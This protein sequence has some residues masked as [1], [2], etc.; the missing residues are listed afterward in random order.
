VGKN[1]DV[2]TPGCVYYRNVSLGDIVK[3]A[4]NFHVD[5]TIIVLERRIDVIGSAILNKRN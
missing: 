3:R 4:I 2:S 5:L 1:F